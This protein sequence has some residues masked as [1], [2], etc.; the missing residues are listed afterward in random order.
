MK[1][2]YAKIVILFDSNASCRIL[3]EFDVVYAGILLYQ[4]RLSLILFILEPCSFLVGY[5]GSCCYPVSFRGWPTIH[6][7]YSSSVEKSIIFIILP[8]WL[9]DSYYKI[10][11]ASSTPVSQ[12]YYHESDFQFRQNVFLFLLNL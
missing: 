11:E 1:Y 10:L 9:Q 7:F 12:T 8:L 2:A 6:S 3:S 4:N 5:S